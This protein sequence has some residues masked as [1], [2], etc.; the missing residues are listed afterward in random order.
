MTAQALIS[1]PSLQ[2]RYFLAEELDGQTV[3]A[4]LTAAAIVVSRAGSTTIL[5]LLLMAS[6]VLLFQFQRILVVI[7]EPMPML[8]PRLEPLQ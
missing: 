3:N 1:N 5:K 8:T 6:L 4:L 7:S 2:N